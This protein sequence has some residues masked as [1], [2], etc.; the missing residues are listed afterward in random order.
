[1]YVGGHFRELD[2]AVYRFGKKVNFVG[3]THFGLGVI[4]ATFSSG[5]SIS[6]WNDGSSTD[7][8][9]GWAA[10][11]PNPGGAGTASGL[12]VGGDADTIKGET[13]KRIALL[14]L[15]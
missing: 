10:M 5:M 11:L 15:P 12:W 3:H 8:G 13:G 7:R 6:G 4:A 2:H 9:A 1:V 14:P